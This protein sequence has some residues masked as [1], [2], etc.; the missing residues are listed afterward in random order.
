MPERRNA[1]TGL[2]NEKDWHKFLVDTFQP[3]GGGDKKWYKRMEQYHPPPPTYPCVAEH[4]IETLSE[5]EVGPFGDR[6]H[7][8]E[9]TTLEECVELLQMMGHKV[10]VSKPISKTDLIVELKKFLPH[11]MQNEATDFSATED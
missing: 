3:Y 5:P 7:V 11:V 9:F 8:I 6:R 10:N 2:Q 1:K 4:R